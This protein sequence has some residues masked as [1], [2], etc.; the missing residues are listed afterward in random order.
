MLLQNI[1]E[2]ISQATVEGQSR[3][4]N[5]VQ[6]QLGHLNIGKLIIPSFIIT[7]YN[8]LFTWKGLKD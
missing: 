8:K 5:Y 6:G 4:R 3:Q 7:F 2:V 1:W